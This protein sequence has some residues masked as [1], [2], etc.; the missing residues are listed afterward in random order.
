[1]RTTLTF[2]LSACLVI[3]GCDSIPAKNI[4]EN[5]ESVGNDLISAN[6]KATTALMKGYRHLISDAENPDSAAPFVIATVVN[7]DNLDKSSTLGRLITEHVSAK[8]TQLGYNMVELKIRKDIY[9]KDREGELLLTRE[10]KK[11]AN[12]HKAQAIIVGTYAD[13]QNTVFINL[14]LVN[15]STGIVISAVD[16]LLVKE[17]QIQSL[18]K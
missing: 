17:R 18:L 4:Q 14:K 8:M 2:L 15:P 9:I 3:S 16:Y 13:S 12:S 6:Y 1:M 11:L 10:L 7:I 5:H